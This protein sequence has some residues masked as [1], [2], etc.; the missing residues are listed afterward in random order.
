MQK[1]PQAFFNIEEVVPDLRARFNDCLPDPKKLLRAAIPVKDPKKHPT[2]HPAGVDRGSIF[3]NDGQNF[4][5]WEVD[6]LRA[7]FRGNKQPPVLG[8]YPEHYNDSFILFEIHVLEISNIFGDRR[9][10]EMKEIYS[11]LRR[12]PDGR[13]LGFVHD[14]IWQAAA[15]VLGTRPL[16]QAE[17]E[18]ILA[19]LERSCRTFE[20][21]PTSCNYVASIRM[22]LKR[23]SH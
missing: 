10:R 17:F 3:L 18:A 1:T 22:V 8:D 14:Y 15:L 23:T 21:G 20:L 11:T 6:S 4:W 5:S 9:D 12:R 16:S 7:L 2:P 19:R 13:S